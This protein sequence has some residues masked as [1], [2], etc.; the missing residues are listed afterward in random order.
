MSNGDGSKKVRQAR[1]AHH[2]SVALTQESAEE[3]MHAAAHALGDSP[4]VHAQADQISAAARRHREEAKAIR[5]TD[6]RSE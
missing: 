2:D 3:T 1:A 4:A 5:A 6:E